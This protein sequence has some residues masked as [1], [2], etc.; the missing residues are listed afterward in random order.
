MSEGVRVQGRRARR[1]AQRVGYRLRHPRRLPAT[2]SVVVPVFNV[3]PYVAEALESLINQTYRR[4]EIVVV[5]DGSQDGSI[6]V[7]R[8]YMAHDRRVVLVRQPNQGLSAA[9]NT[10]IAAARGEYLAFLDPDDVIEP[11]AF[12]TLVRTIRKSR[13]DFVVCCYKRI[14]NNRKV[15]PGP[16]IQAVHRKPRLR[17][18]LSDDYDILVNAVAWSKLYRRTF[19]DRAGLSFPTGL[20][21]EDQPVSAGAYLAARAFDVVPDRLVNWRIRPDGLSISQQVR[22]LRDLQNRLESLEATLRVLRPDRGAYNARLAQLLNNDLPHSIRELPH[23]LPAF[24]TALHEAMGELLPQVTPQVW[25]HVAAP[26]KLAYRIIESGSRDDIVVFVEKGGLA[27]R[28]YATQIRPDGPHCVAGSAAPVPF[29]FEE[30]RTRMAPSELR[31]DGSI[32]RIW[33]EADGRLAIAGWAYVSNVEDPRQ[34]VTVHAVGRSGE[35][36]ELAVAQVY[37]PEVE[38]VANHRFNSYPG[39]GFV[40]RLDPADLPKTGRWNLDFTVSVS[41][42]QVRG[43]ARNLGLPLHNRQLGG[44]FTD[45]GRLVRPVR[46]PSGELSILVERITCPVVALASHDGRLELTTEGL[47]REVSLA[48]LSDQDEQIVSPVITTGAGRSVTS[49]DVRALLAHADPAGEPGSPVNRTDTSSPNSA[50]GSDSTH[51]E[52]NDIH[53]TDTEGGTDT[54]DSTDG[55]GNLHWRRRL[56]AVDTSGSPSGV[57]AA[58][59]KDVRRIDGLDGV[60]LESGTN[61]R[62]AIAAYG[63]VVVLQDVNLLDDTLI[64]RG[65]CHGVSPSASLHVTGQ[66]FDTSALLEPGE[67]GEFRCEVRLRTSWWGREDV[68]LRQGLYK[69]VVREPGGNCVSNAL[70]PKLTASARQALPMTYRS[71]RI[72]AELVCTSKGNLSL[73]VKA[74][75]PASSRSR[76]GQAELQ[77]WY[78]LAPIE[79]RPRTV[80]FR[81]FYGESTTCCALG[82]HQELVRRGTDLDLVWAVK[83]FSVPVPHGGRPVV[84]NSPEWYEMLASAKYVVDNVHQPDYFLKRPG[85]IVVQTFHGYPFK[86]MGHPYWVDAGY[87]PARI[88][89]FD[90]RARDWDYVVSPATY[91]TPLLRDA[92]RYSGEMLELGYPRNDVLLRD[93][94]AIRDRTRAL[95]GIEPHQTVVLYAPT[96]RD[97]LSSNEFRS[98]MVDHLD[99]EDFARQT[100]GDAVLLVRG[101]AMNARQGT[102]VAGQLG[103]VDVTDYPEVSDLI[104]AADVAVLD[105]S[106][107]RFDVGVA[108][109]PMIFLVPDLARYEA[110][111]GW[112]FDYA[113]TA[114]GPFV[115]DTDELVEALS[116]LGRLRRDYA[117]RY[118]AFRSQYLDL[119]DGFAGQ[120][121]VD[122]V[123]ADVLVESP[124]RS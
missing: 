46:S 13:S 22:D 26:M 81:T 102:A 95:L 59:G 97:W 110:E 3:E 76:R 100:H 86:Q 80:L 72:S 60:L 106:S 66:A 119:D 5:D 103:V 43:G 28:N 16:W 30:W 78:R 68:A 49:I 53:G 92:F 23:T 112:L 120:R 122:A 34:T 65:W 36:I 117:D 62:L 6:D 15:E 104:L 57:A 115:N 25:A 98:D 33:W 88:A 14:V 91:A 21:Y 93:D 2:V 51:S 61:G 41:G 73:Q 56:A 35:G 85:Q 38:V 108:G 31:F 99:Y 8:H 19:W 121:V 42:M 50:D 113:P 9:R 58:L 77:E 89:S 83:D 11:H 1:V 4:L 10:G 96:Y 39:S 107:I 63:R 87:S 7:V 47:L 17:A 64:V 84:Y 69:V 67:R 79:L 74:P 109:K 29:G 71:S 37:D 40:A 44:R 75:Q 70:V 24:Y 90:S 12:E 55:A 54:A 101:H 45:G 111:R 82:I 20:N 27:S 52:D 116:D 118:A 94:G 114:P 105:Y 18:R 48:A 124:A 123:F 32:R